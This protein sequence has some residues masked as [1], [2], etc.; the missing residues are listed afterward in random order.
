MLALALLAAVPVPGPTFSGEDLAAALLGPVGPSAMEVAAEVR[1]VGFWAGRPI[2]DEA[3]SGCHPDVD[4]QWRQSAHRFS[5]FNNPYY[6]L[7]TEAFRRERG[8]EA[9][10]FCSGCHEPV[11]AATSAV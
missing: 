1:R 10:R 9:S 2:G 8:P 6:R 11:L 4:A 7:A 5:S 3:C